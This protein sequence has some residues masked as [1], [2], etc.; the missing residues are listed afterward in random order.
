M[1]LIYREL[2]I[3]LTYQWF[4]EIVKKLPSLENIDTDA[5]GYIPE[6]DC[7]DEML[8]SLFDIA[9]LLDLPRYVEAIEVDYERQTA[10]VDCIDDQEM[11]DKV[12]ARLTDAGWKLTNYDACK[13]VFSH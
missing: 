5:F 10:S 9:F 6:Y 1:L 2:N 3:K 12:N 4:N 8:L 7:C 13:S 11:L